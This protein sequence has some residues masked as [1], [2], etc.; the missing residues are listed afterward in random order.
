ML[1]KQLLAANTG[2]G[3]RQ[4]AEIL[5]CNPRASQTS[6]STVAQAVGVDVSDV[7]RPDSRIGLNAALIARAREPVACSLLRSKAAPKPTTS[8]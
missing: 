3:S 7:L 5:A 6:L 8:A 1:P 2:T 4:I